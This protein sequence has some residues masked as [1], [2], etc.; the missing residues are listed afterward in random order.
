MSE[1]EGG[2]DGEEGR[3]RGALFEEGTERDR[4]L[5]PLCSAL[6][7]EAFFVFCCEIPD[8]GG[9]GGGGGLSSRPTTFPSFGV[10]IGIPKMVK[11]K[12]RTIISRIFA[13]EK[14]PPR[15]HPSIHP[16][17]AK[18][19]TAPAP[20][21]LFSSPLSPEQHR[22]RKLLNERSVSGFFRKRF[23]AIGRQT[24]RRPTDA[25]SGD[26]GG[27]GG[28][29]QIAIFNIDSSSSSAAAAAAGG[30]RA[31]ARSIFAEECSACARCQ[32]SDG[33]AS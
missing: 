24:P 30:R 6:L 3:R 23:S 26:G 17:D 27:G 13:L 18:T 16:A 2:L 14:F 19:A 33:R 4:L 5:P 8:G 11:I 32:N 29:A 22:E 21:P 31:V 7:C 20:L 9:G 28:D 12:L 15:R 25:T 1:R 10:Q